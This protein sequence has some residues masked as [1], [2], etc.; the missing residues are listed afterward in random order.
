MLACLSL[1][2]DFPRPVRG[3]DQESAVGQAAHQVKQQRR[4]AR[5][6]PLEVIQQQDQRSLPGHHTEKT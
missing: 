3:H 4:A 2:A 5:I 6:N 1:A